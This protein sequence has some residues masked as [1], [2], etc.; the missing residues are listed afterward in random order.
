VVESAHTV[1]QVIARRIEALAASSALRAVLTRYAAELCAWQS[2]RTAR[3]WLDVLERVSAR[4]REVDPNSARLLETV[5]ANLFKLIAYKDEYEVARLMTDADGLA[6]AREVA[7]EARED[8]VAAP[9]AAPARDRSRAQDRHP[10]LGR[11][12]DQAAREGQAAARH[13]ARSV[14]L[15]AGAPDRARAAARV[16]R[17][18]RSG[19]HELSADRST[20]RSRSPRCP[21]SCAATRTSRSAA[22]RPTASAC[23]RRS[24]AERSIMRRTSPRARAARSLPLLAEVTAG[25]ARTQS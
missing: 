17:G 6:A 2:A 10:G 23:A 20:T 11:A 5:A 1:P 4:E 8:R 19:A 13:A 16:R 15:R 21:T 12:R 9:P 14:R 7:G 25:V 22:S 24:R 18:D 3:S